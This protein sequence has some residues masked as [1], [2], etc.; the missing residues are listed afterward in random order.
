LGRRNSK[1]TRYDGLDQFGKRKYKRKNS[2]KKT[3]S[4]EWTD[5]LLKQITKMEE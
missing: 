4:K 1:Q 2:G 3:D 5:V